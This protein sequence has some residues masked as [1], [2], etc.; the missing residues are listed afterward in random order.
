[1]GGTFDPIHIG[2]LV[3]AQEVY[4]QFDLDKVI[5]MVAGRHPLKTVGVSPP[6]NRLEMVR[7]AIDDN[8]HF[9]ASDYEVNRHEISFTVDTLRYLRGSYPSDTEFFFIT[10]ADAVFEILEWKDAETLS[11][12]TIFVGATRPGYDLE[13]TRQRYE[14]SL[15]NFDIRYL[16]VPA[17]AVSSTDIR[18]RVAAG[19][20]VRY[21]V[22]DRVTQYINKHR[23][24]RD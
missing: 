16:E 24:Y 10:G 9:E 20:D 7:I 6:K 15:Q 1:M 12:M 22:G 19:R 5:F 3:T 8:G 18:A 13:A 21:L 23:L 11:D 4:E 2:H 17:L 14:N